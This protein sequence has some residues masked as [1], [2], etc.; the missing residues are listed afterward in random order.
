MVL[1]VVHHDRDAVMD[2]TAL[3][4][5]PEMPMWRYLRDVIAPAC[6]LVYL[7]GTVRAKVHTPELRVVFNNEV[8]AA[9]LGSLVRDWDSLVISPWPKDGITVRSLEGNAC[10]LLVAG[11]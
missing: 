8:N 7:D 5:T 3:E 2:R 9:P 11:Q 1:W 4:Y 6:G 10:E